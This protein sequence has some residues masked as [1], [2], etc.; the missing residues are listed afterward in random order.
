MILDNQYKA[1]I[2]PR[3]GGR[4]VPESVYDDL[5]SAESVGRFYNANVKGRYSEQQA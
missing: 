4:T 3:W 1:V 5:I 2:S